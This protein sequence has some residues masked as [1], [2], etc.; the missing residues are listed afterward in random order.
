MRPKHSSFERAIGSCQHDAH[1]RKLCDLTLTGLKQQTHTHRKEQVND[2][3]PR[4]N[5][6]QLKAVPSGVLNAAP[7]VIIELPNVPA[8]FLDITGGA[9]PFSLS[10][11]NSLC[12]NRDASIVT[13]KSDNESLRLSST[14]RSCQA[15]SGRQSKCSSKH[16]HCAL[17]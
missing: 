11:A 14:I 12:C 17:L 6:A 3:S 8:A 5:D 10:G 9:W 7:A 13:A 1:S 2:H 4:R 15:C 16:R